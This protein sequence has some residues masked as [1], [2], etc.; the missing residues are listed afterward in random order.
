MN[1]LRIRYL[2]IQLP[3][4][5]FLDFMHFVNSKIF[6]CQEQALLNTYQDTSFFRSNDEK[7]N[8]YNFSFH[9]SYDWL[10]AA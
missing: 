8:V 3:V 6:S 5:L 4:K 9:Q 10:Q 2:Y 1:K 7:I